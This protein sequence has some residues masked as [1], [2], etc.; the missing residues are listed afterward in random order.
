MDKQPIHVLVVEDNSTDAFL[1]QEALQ[2]ASPFSFQ[3]TQVARLD[4]GMERLHTEPFDVILLDLGLPD[5]QGLET[6]RKL[7]TEV[8][9]IP[10]VMLTGLDDDTLAKQALQEGAQDYLVKGQVTSPVLVR[11][12]RYAIERKR[13]EET[14]RRTTEELARSNAEL[15]QFAYIVSHDLQEPLRQVMNYTQLLTERYQGKLDAKAD[16]FIMYIMDGVTRLQT[17]IKDLLTYSRAGRKDISFQL[18]SIQEIVQQVMFDLEISLKETGAVITCDPLPTIRAVPSQMRQLWQNLIGNALKFRSTEPPRIHISAKPQTTHW[19][20]SVQDNGIGIDPQHAERIFG[21]FQR[22]H[23]RVEY[24][25]TGIGLAICKKVVEFHG[26]RIW[27]ES[28]LHQGATF[29]F[30]LPRSSGPSSPEAT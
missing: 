2:E 10:V 28:Q 29:Y 5:S 11:T 14:L 22:L 27:V 19:L 15:E 30:T 12:I 25:G 23:T 17:L 8:T 4:E 9:S 1:L 26:G 20:F 18:T 16:K 24:P 7:Q 3:V 6:F 13:A 21:V